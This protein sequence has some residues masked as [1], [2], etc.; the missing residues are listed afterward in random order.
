VNSQTKP[1]NFQQ[2]LL[3][4]SRF[5][6]FPGALDTLYNLSSKYSVRKERSQIES[7]GLMSQ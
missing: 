7:V 3:I 5:P 4:S 1:E 6:G 2:T